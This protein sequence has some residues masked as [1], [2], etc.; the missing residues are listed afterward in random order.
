MS[1]RFTII[2]LSLA[3]VLFGLSWYISGSVV[4]RAQALGSGKIQDTDPRMSLIYAGVFTG[5]YLLAYVAMR[6]IY[7]KKVS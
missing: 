6:D 2:Y 3:P 5:I 4:P 7:R 1:R